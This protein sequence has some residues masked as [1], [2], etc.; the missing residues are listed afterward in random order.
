MPTDDDRLTRRTFLAGAGAVLA[1]SLVPPPR[2]SAQS[3]AQS[4]ATALGEWIDDDYGLPAYHYTGPMRF[5]DSPKRDGEAMIPDDPFFLTGNYRLTLF[6]HA[7]GLYQIL[8]GERAWGRMNQGDALWGGANHAAVEISGQHHSLIGLD[9]PAAAAATKRFGVG[10]ARYDYALA[11]SLNVT[12]TLSVAPSEKVGEGTSAFLTQVLVR[13]TGTEPITLR[14][15]ETV[16]AQYEQLHAQWNGF[17]SNISWPIQPPQPSASGVVRADFTAQAKRPLTFPPP[18]QMSRLEQ[19]PPTLF[20]KAISGGALP[21][22][23]TDPA[24]HRNLGIAADLTLQPGQQ[25]ALSFITGYIREADADAHTYTHTIDKLCARL[26]LPPAAPKSLGSAYGE[27]WL[28]TVAPFADEPDTNLRREMR[29]NAATLEAMATWREYYDET[30]IPQGTMYDYIWGEMASSRDLAQQALPF[31]HTNPAIARSTLRF[32]MKRTLPDGEIKLNDEGFGWSPSGAQ[33]TSDQQLYFFLLLAEY[34]RVTRDGSI[35]TEQ[36]GYYPLENSGHDTGLAHV[37]QAFLF[38][39]DR[40]GVGGHGIIRRWNSD[41]NDM[42]GWWRSPI[43]YNTEFEVGESHM[44][45]AMAI[46]ILGDLAAAIDA[47]GDP[48]AAE[49]T[50]AMREYRAELHTAWDRDL[51]DRAFPRRAWMDSETPL[52]EDN[53]WL[54]PQGYTL[55]IPEFSDERKR[56][57]FAELQHRL[58]PG[59]A[60]DAR[61]IEKPTPKSATPAGSRENGGFWYALNGPLVLGVA[62]FDRPA[63]HNLLRHMTFA[64]YAKNFPTYWTGQWSASDSLDSSLL[65]TSGLSTAIPWCAHAHAWPLYCYLRLRALEQSA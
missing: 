63:A 54:E 19:F 25:H 44:N 42:F 62:T 52:G 55:L 60:M 4:P 28:R 27:A 65:P 30:V 34:V 3:A 13:N 6:T 38:L 1:A 49:L 22:T 36:I 46:V 59:E 20:V 39:R 5:P 40:V 43:P 12:R 35:L 29:W 56:R 7:S 33:Q 64:N 24:G 8:T 14:Y 57:L 37:R 51:G 21:H 41:W 17:D 53:M 2:S 61:Q 50:A 48:G 23:E 58:L 18:G 16:R 26:A 15:S 11:P 31:C 32:I 47:A 45:S 9:E 10:F